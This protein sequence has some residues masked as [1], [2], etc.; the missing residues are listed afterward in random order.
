MAAPMTEVRV[1][2]P[3]DE[4]DNGVVQGLMWGLYWEDREQQERE[5]GLRK[6]GL[7][8]Q[9][10]DLCDEWWRANGYDPDKLPSEEQPCGE[11]SGTQWVEKWI[12][13]RAFSQELWL[14]E[15]LHEARVR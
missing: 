13:V 14:E 8:S 6:A 5:E 2:V 10:A 1:R 12:D 4:C 3:C 9:A 7:Y 11:C 15:A